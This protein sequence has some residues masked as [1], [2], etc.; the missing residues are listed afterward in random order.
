MK[1]WILVEEVGTPHTQAVR[2]RLPPVRGVGGGLLHLG[3]RPLPLRDG[4]SL[5]GRICSLF[6]I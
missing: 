2:G 3:G 4:S 1:R 5:W 6:Y